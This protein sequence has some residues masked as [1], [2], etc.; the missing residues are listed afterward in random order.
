MSLHQ[1]LGPH[2]LAGG[3]VVL[4]DGPQHG[5]LA[6]VQHAPPPGQGNR[7]QGAADPGTPVLLSAKCDGRLGAPAPSR[8]GPG[9]TVP[10]PSARPRPDSAPGATA[11]HACPRSAARRVRRGDRRRTGW[12]WSARP[13][14][15]AARSWAGTGAPTGWRWS[16]RTATGPPGLPAPP[17]LLPPGRVRGDAGPTGPRE[18]RLPPRPAPPRAPSRC[19]GRG[20]GSP[21]RRGSGSRAA[22]TRS[23]WRR[24]GATT[25]DGGGRRGGAA[26]ASTSC[27]PWQPR[28]A[29]GPGAASGCSV[30]HLVPGSRRRASPRRC[31]AAHPGARAR[32][33]SPVRGRVA[34]RAPPGGGHHGLAPVRPASAWKEGTCVALGW[35]DDTAAAWRG[36]PAARVRRVRRPRA[37][38]SRPGRGAHRLRLPDVTRRR[39]AGDVRRGTRAFARGGRRRRATMGT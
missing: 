13:A 39:R 19:P 9:R 25:C 2:R 10:D 28:S 38:L 26:A 15:G 11:T 4:D 27:R 1:R 31:V 6:V 34:G 12:S 24:C 36:C 37:E 32:A 18:P 23:W 21:G 5:E 35:P 29:P 14:A 22:T 33:R 30:D 17:G 16:W 3:D 8:H 20:P 7:R